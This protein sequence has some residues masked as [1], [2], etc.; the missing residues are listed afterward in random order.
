[1]CTRQSRYQYTRRSD[2]VNR[3]HSSASGNIRRR[4]KKA[5]DRLRRETK[6]P[7]VG[8]LLSSEWATAKRPSSCTK[9]GAS[10]RVFVLTNAS[11]AYVSYGRRVLGLENG[12][13]VGDV[14][15]PHELRAATGRAHVTY[16]CMVYGY[17]VLSA[18]RRTKRRRRKERY[19]LCYVR[20][21]R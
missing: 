20:L 3:E 15:V 9:S 16:V 10:A 14:R 21:S 6:N 11:P 2:T 4:E 17:K 5:D 8:P 12:S 7:V 1:M 19:R 18:K 13:A